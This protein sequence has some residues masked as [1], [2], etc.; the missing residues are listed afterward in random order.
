MDYQ[1]LPI[2]KTARFPRPRITAMNCDARDDIRLTVTN[3]DES[4]GPRCVT[5]RFTQ[6]RPMSILNVSKRQISRIVCP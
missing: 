1:D 4:S 3:A 6:R 2:I 5:L